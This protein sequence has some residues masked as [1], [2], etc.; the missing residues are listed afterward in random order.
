[1]AKL[2][3]NVLVHGMY[4]VVIGNREV[5]FYPPAVPNNAHSYLAGN[6]MQEAPLNPG[7]EYRLTGTARGKRPTLDA[8][9][10]YFD[11]VFR[12]GKLNPRLAYC[13]L[14]LP[15]PD[16][17]T[18]LRL[19]AERPGVP[20]FTGKPKLY[21]APQALPE[22]VVL[23]YGGVSADAKL[24]PLL[25]KPAPTNGI[26]NLHL[27]AM[28]PGETPAGHPEA[29]LAVAGKLM[30]FANLK[31]DMSYSMQPPPPLDPQPA[32]AG[33]ASEDEESLAERQGASGG[34]IEPRVTSSLDC[35]SMFVY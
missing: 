33:V 12:K 9:H 6:W 34:G 23:T 7:G 1:M 31:M 21:R 10:P 22:V 27:W 15:F 16:R 13:T 25:W 29:A 2:T 8:V 14:K 3:L 20:F 24:Q 30:G 18:P 32:V 26:A 5:T 19:T 35:A 28:P 11:A 4:V 17:I